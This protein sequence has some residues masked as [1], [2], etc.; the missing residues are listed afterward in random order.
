MPEKQKVVSIEIARKRFD[1][2]HCEHYCVEIDEA[3][4]NVV[5]KKCGVELNPIWVLSRFAREQTQW[6]ANRKALKEERERMELKQ[7]TKCQHCGAMT[8]IK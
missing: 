2:K 3:R 8:K 6:D 7:R 4:C 1:D 5:C